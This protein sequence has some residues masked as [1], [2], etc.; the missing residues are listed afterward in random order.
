MK[1]LVK[2]V[3]VDCGDTR[4][5]GVPPN[6]HRTTRPSMTRDVLMLYVHRIKHCSATASRVKEHCPT[7]FKLK[8]L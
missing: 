4:G 3:E 1:T 7:D 5:G 2:R 8:V 6:Q